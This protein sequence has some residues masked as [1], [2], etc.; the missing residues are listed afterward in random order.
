M[1]RCETTGFR[2]HRDRPS[3][4]DY[5]LS[6][7]CNGGA[8]TPKCTAIHV[9][10]SH[11]ELHGAVG[12]PRWLRSVDRN[13]R[14]ADRHCPGS[15]YP[16]IHTSMHTPTP[17]HIHPYTG[18]HVQKVLRWCDAPWTLKRMQGSIFGEQPCENDPDACPI[19][20]LIVV[21]AARFEV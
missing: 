5:F 10:H 11:L 20:T 18:P 21:E 14:G 2:D 17:P 1:D 12:R 13:L 7:R 6:A 3:R 4:I 8:I 15:I 19:F 16:H 9:R